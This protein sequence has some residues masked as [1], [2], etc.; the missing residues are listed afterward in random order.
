MTLSQESPGNAHAVQIRLQAYL[1]LSQKL[2]GD[3]N[4]GCK[5]CKH[6]GNRKNSVKKH[7]KANP[8]SCC[9]ASFVQEHQT[10]Q[11]RPDC[12]CECDF[13]RQE[14]LRHIDKVGS[15]TLNVDK[16]ALQTLNI[17]RVGYQTLQIA[18]VG[19]QTRSCGASDL[20]LSQG[21]CP[22]LRQV[23]PSIRRAASADG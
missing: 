5:Q 13:H 1:S 4:A 15:Q 8:C 12:P 11:A 16:V 9:P 2:L 14:N 7:S 21:P 18:K 10:C 23:P 6:P 19:S 3:V 17:D 20:L 22:S